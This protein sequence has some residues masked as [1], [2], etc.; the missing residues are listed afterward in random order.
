MTNCLLDLQKMFSL[1]F[2]NNKKTSDCVVI[3][4]KLSLTSLMD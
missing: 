2:K 1:T 4:V 3:Y